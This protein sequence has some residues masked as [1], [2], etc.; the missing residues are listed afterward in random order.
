MIDLLLP[1]LTPHQQA[2]WAADCAERVLHLFEAA[3]PG[4]NRP[5]LAIEA[6][7]RYAARAACAARAVG[8]ADEQD[9]QV[10]RLLFY[11][12]GDADRALGAYTAL[13]LGAGVDGILN[14]REENTRDC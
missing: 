2:L 3:R 12:T 13:A 9:W 8:A 4:D 11:I 14:L 1:H 10:R 5:R 6:A 7:R